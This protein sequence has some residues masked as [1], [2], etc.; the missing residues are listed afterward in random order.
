MFTN[1]YIEYRKMM[2]L[3][4]PSSKFVT[5]SGSAATGAPSMSYMG[6]FGAY[7]EEGTTYAPKDNATT[8]VSNYT[9]FPGVRFGT[10]SKPAT[11]ED[12]AL[13]KMLTSG[14]TITNHRGSP[15]LI[16]KDGVYS[17][18]STFSVTNTTWAELNIWEIGYYGHICNIDYRHSDILFERTVLP[19][20]IKIP[21]GETR[22]VEYRIVF[23]QIM[24]VE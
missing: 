17:Y 16:A 4:E 24:N 7:M 20:P 13:E 19:E 21:P 23:N 15:G 6:D 11:R 9:K 10:G 2:F 5:H 14:I 8:N 3:G 22:A 1:N 18:V 12:Y